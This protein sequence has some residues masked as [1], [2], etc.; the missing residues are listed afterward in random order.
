[1]TLLVDTNILVGVLR[2][3]DAAVNWLANQKRVP[4]A[5]VVTLTELLA[6]ARSQSEE[7]DILDLVGPMKPLPVTT[8]I[9][10]TAGLHKKQYGR[11]HGTGLPDALIAATAQ[12]HD[13]KLATLN[14]KHFPMFKGLK[15]PY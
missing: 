2:N 8:A 10:I 15:A 13:L 12:H 5:S 6:G 1:M 9:A 3:V 7:M 11:T 14:I 4:R